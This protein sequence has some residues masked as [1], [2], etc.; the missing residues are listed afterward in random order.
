[1]TGPMNI[2]NPG[3]YTVQEIADKVIE[4]TGTKSEIVYRKLPSDD[5]KKRRPDITLAKEILGWKP[6]IGLDQG[7]RLTIEFFKTLVPSGDPIA[8]SSTP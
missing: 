8:S 6:T 4:F 7:L 2:G 1:V 3:E 5:P